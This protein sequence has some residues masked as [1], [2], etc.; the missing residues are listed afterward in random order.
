MDYREFV[1]GRRAVKYPERDGTQ[2]EVLKT[3]DSWSGFFESAVLQRLQAPG[4]EPLLGIEETNQ[5]LTQFE[6]WVNGPLAELRTSLERYTTDRSQHLISYTNFH[7]MSSFFLQ[8]WFRLLVGTSWGIHDAR[9]Y[10]S[11]TQDYLA[12]IS[13]EMQKRREKIGQS[14]PRENHMVSTLTGSLSEV[15]VAIVALHPM[16][17]NPELLLLP[18]PGNFEH[19]HKKEKSADFLIFDTEK[20]EATGMQVKTKVDQSEYEVYDPNFVFLVDTA[21]DLDD[22]LARRVP[23]KATVTHVNHPGLI[24]AHHISNWPK[25][26]NLRSHPWLTS[27]VGNE[28]QFME[29]KFYANM[30]TRHTKDMTPV[31]QK[32]IGERALQHLYQRPFSEEIHLDAV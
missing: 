15:D 32:R 9:K 10:N 27:Y 23:G 16:K 26:M 8:Q 31:A 17:S 2:Q 18:A 14:L 29:L 21:I 11:E 13:I 28:R 25:Q 5:L 24:A 20:H 12:I 30:L 7:F 22:V 4:N 3:A 1:A 6:D 19:G